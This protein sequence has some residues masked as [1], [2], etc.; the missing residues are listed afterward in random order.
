MSGYFITWSSYIL[1]CLSFL[2]GIASLIV[3][4]LGYVKANKASIEAE[5][6]NKEIARINERKSTAADWK[7]ELVGIAASGRE[8][9]DGLIQ[10]LARISSSEL[11]NEQ[12]KN[13][14]KR[15][16]R[17]IKNQIDDIDYKFLNNNI[18]NDMNEAEGIIK[19]VIDSLLYPSK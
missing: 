18:Q 14:T 5:N 11:V 6:A 15:L 17:I 8:R 10:L 12:Q 1:T 4:F 3:S 9:A 16:L 2:I 13:D 7:I 19:S